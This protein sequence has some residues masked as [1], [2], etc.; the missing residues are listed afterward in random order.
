MD[1]S[2]QI[3]DQDTKELIT[4]VIMVA[5][6]S[7]IADDEG[8]EYTLKLTEDKAL[9]V[10]CDFFEEGKTVFIHYEIWIDDL[11]I[12]QTEVPANRQIH[13]PHDQDIIDIVCA[14]SDRVIKQE[15]Q[16][17]NRGFIANKLQHKIS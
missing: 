8:V 12:A 14:C 2:F 15:I 11:L 9:V 7:V 4:S 10:S 17:R 3:L 13:L 6:I 5:P 1:N 16:L